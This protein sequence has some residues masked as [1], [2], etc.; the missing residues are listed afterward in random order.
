M[1]SVS[2]WLATSLL[3]LLIG[4]HG[5]SGPGI[6]PPPVPDQVKAGGERPPPKS[7]SPAKGNWFRRNNGC[8]WAPQVK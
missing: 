1:R 5:D 4:C 7:Q 2:P 3:G 8:R 6:A